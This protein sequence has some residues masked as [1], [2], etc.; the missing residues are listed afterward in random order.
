MKYTNASPAI[1][2]YTTLNF[3]FLS[4]R[5]ARGKLRFIKRLLIISNCRRNI[6]TA[7]RSHFFWYLIRCG[8]YIVADWACNK[9]FVRGIFERTKSL[10]AEIVM[11]LTGNVD[12][13]VRSI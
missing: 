7:A 3:P 6:V 4:L 10:A 8:K 2:A 5:L 11:G 13:A 12:A 1:R 9:E